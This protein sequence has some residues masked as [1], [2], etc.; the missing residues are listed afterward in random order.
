MFEKIKNSTSIRYFEY[1]AYLLTASFFLGHAAL[2][3]CYV[4]FLL[5]SFKSV[6]KNFSLKEFL[7]NKA[8]IFPCIFFI[9]KL[10]LL[11]F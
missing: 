8:L 2:S 6:I 9:F 1:S 4:I 3:V 10:F 5:T 7:S 11:V